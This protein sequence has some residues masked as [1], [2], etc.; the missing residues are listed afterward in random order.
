MWG[1]TNNAVSGLVNFQ[2]FGIIV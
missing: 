2:G 1:T